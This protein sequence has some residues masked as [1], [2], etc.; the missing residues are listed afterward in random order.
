[1]IQNQPTPFSVMVLSQ[2][3]L[4]QSPYSP[5]EI[6][7]FLYE[8]LGQFR[9]SKE[10]IGRAINFALSEPN[11]Q[12]G[13]VVLCLDQENHLVG[14]VVM[15]RPGMVGYVPENFL[16]YI[17]VKEGMQ[18]Q[19]IGTYLFSQVFAQVSGSISL[20]V[21]HDNPAKRL[22]Q[23]LGFTEKYAEMRLER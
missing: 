13:E 10:S 5:L 1:M 17:A 2:E 3:T 18:G 8:N 16:V 21:E 23:K 12:K 20:H 7:A 9:D 4:D 15:N 22:Y 11:R 14:V 6:Q 19:G